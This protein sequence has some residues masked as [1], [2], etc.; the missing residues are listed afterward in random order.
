MFCVTNRAI[1][2]VQH[3]TNI[4]VKVRF[5]PTEKVKFKSNLNH[6]HRLYTK[7]ITAETKSIYKFNMNP[8]EGPMTYTIGEIAKK[9]NVAP[10][11]LR[12]YDKVGLL[13]FV[14]RS[15]GGIRVFHD[16][17]MDWLELIECMKHTGMPIKEIKHFIDYCVEGDSRINERLSI[18]RNQ[19]DRV[20][21]EIEHL[22]ARLS[23]LEFK[24]WFYEETKRRGSCDFYE[25]ATPD[26]IPKGYHK[27]FERKWRA[28]AEAVQNGESPK[29][30]KTI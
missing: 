1:L 7:Y 12:Y 2:Y 21:V 22:Q 23:M 9:L 20:L 28:E 15:V 4:E 29:K 14:E 10:S 5:K 17:D 19:R 11:T 3:V 8:K 25:T 26:D 16:E 30:Y 13:P 18:I 6:I 24:T 27:F